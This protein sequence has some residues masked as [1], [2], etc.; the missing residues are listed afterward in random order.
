MELI[1]LYYFSEVAKDLHITRTA[2]R[3]YVTQQTLS[4]HIARL[5]DY[6]GMP[7]FYRRPKL[8]LTTAGE[9]VLAFANSVGLEHANLRDSLSD[10]EKQE[11]GVIHFGASILR[12]NTSLPHV[13][14]EFSA[15]YPKVELRLTEGI[16]SHLLPMVAEGRLDFAIVLSDKPNP[17]LTEH[18]LMDDHIYLCVSDVLLRKYYG[19]EAEAIKRAAE[20]GANVK[21]F[22]KLP[23]CMLNNRMG[24]MV[25]E[26]FQDAQV[27]PWQYISCTNTNLNTTVC[28]ERLTASFIPHVSLAANQ[29]AIPDD[30][31]IFPLH[32]H[33]MPVVQRSTLI[34][35]TDRYLSRFNKYFLDLLYHHYADVEHIRFDRIV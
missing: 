18:H 3:L 28:F 13:L 5:E 23:F 16:S 11:S 12:L 25:R 30:L 35:R 20:H 15:R 9:R 31:N 4:N 21:D 22:A 19:E 29:D 33:G 34:R 10:I 8:S 7:L 26:C 14:P 6:Y 2:D 17:K 27:T 1:S 24:D 32:L